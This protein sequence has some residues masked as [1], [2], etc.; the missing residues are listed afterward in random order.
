[1]PPKVSY[2][3]KICNLFAASK[4]H[5]MLHHPVERIHIGE[6][7]QHYLVEP[8]LISHKHLVYYVKNINLKI[9]FL[10]LNLRARQSIQF[11]NLFIKR[12][13]LNIERGRAGFYLAHIEHVIDKSYQMIA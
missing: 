13:L 2:F 7:I 10:G 9:L 8:Q 11:F 3:S 12:K 4:F 1:M 6:N 5:N